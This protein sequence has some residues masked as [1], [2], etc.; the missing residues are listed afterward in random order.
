MFDGVAVGAIATSSRVPSA[1][2]TNPWASIIGVGETCVLEIG[3]DFELLV[4][5]AARGD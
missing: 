2:L 1:V 5:K 3:A 4:F